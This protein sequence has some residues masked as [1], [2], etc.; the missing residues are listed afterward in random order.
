SALLDRLRQGE[1]TVLFGTHAVLG[2]DVT[3]KRLSLVVIDEQHR[4]GVGQRNT[5]RA[6]GPGAD[7]L[8]MTATP[9]PRT[10]ALSVYGDLDT[11]VIRHRPVPGAGVST[12]VL[13]SSSRDLAYGALRDSLARG[14]QAYVICPMVSPQEGADELEDVPGLEIDEHGRARQAVTLHDVE[15]ECKNMR[16]LLPDVRVEMLHGHMPAR[17]KEEVIDAFRSG[18]IDVLVATTVVE[19]GVDVPNATMM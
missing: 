2:D 16:R 4:F 6:K 8:V 14:R 7:L 15:S 9:I 13:E 10:L 1:I 18:D 17:R 5:L 12:Q 11:S 19:V 3:F